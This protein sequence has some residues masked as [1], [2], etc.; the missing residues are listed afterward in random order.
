MNKTK[1]ANEELIS[2]ILSMTPEQLEKLL[3]HPDFV[4][5]MAEYRTRK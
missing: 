4:A 2:Y 5:V 1:T 3:K